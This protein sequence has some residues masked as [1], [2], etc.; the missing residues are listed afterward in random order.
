M[1]TNRFIALVAGVLALGVAACGDD[2]QL[3][4]PTP[5][6]PPPPPPVTATMA[7]ASASVAVGNSVVFAVNASG[8]VAGEAA[9]WTC[10]SSNTGIA[11][12]SSTSA[13]C[14]ATG[15]AA[16]DV[17]I[18]ASV[19]KSGE[20]VN[21]GAQLTVT[22]DE[23]PVVSGD[24][25]FILI[26]AIGDGDTGTSDDDGVLSGEVTV[27][28][29]VERGDQELE[30]LSI[31]VDG[32]V[33]DS[34]SFGSSMDMGMAPEPEDA[35]AAAEQA[36]HAFTL[37]FN[38]AAYDDHG[39]ADYA[40]GEHTIS[41][42]LEI[43]IDMADGTHG[44]E[45][46]SSNAITV[47]F[48]NDD[49]V[50]I[51]ATA[52]GN[53]ALDD[54]GKVWYG[55]PG[56]GLAISVVPVLFSGG[57]VNAVTMMT[58]CGD[59]AATD[60][61]APFEFAPDC[62]GEGETNADASPSFTLTV[63]GEAIAVEADDI[64]NGDD[65]IFPINLDYE[66]PGAPTFRPNP[67][68]REGGWINAAVAFTS[69][70]S[71]NKD[72]W[73]KSGGEAGGVG[74]Y[75]AQLRF[76]AVPR[77]DEDN[78]LTEALEATPLRAVPP[79][80]VPDSRTGSSYCVIAAAV[81]DLGNESRLPDDENGTCQ[82]AGVNSINVEDDPDTGAV[83]ESANNRVATGY[84]K[85]LEDLAAAEEAED[86]EAIE[87]AQDALAD[88]GLRAGV[89]TT[90][91]SAEFVGSSLSS[92][93]KTVNVDETDATTAVTQYVLHLEDNRGL[94]A[95]EPVVDTLVYRDDDDDRDG[96][97][98]TVAQ[99]ATP[100]D[101]PLYDVNFAQEGLGYYSYTAQA[102]DMAGNLSAEITRTALHDT[103]VPVSALIFARS[104]ATEYDKTLVMADNLSVRS[105]STV[106][107]A[108]NLPA[109]VG[110]RLNHA[111]VDTYNGALTQS[112]TVR[113]EVEL[114][115]IAVGGAS[116]DG[117]VAQGDVLTSITAY[118]TDQA[119]NSDN[120]EVTLGAAA[121]SVEADGDL[122]T[123][124]GVIAGTYE[125]AVEDDDGAI[126]T[127]DNANTVTRSDETITLTATADVALATTVNPFADGVLFY[128]EVGG[129]ETGQV[130]VP[131]D[132]SDDRTELR[133]IG[134]VAGNAAEVDSGDTTREWTYET[135]V[136]A[137]DF[138]A[139]VGGAGA[140]EIRALGINGSGVAHVMTFGDPATPLGISRR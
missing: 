57:S 26:S 19:T 91:P 117:S 1:K 37:S 122:E 72:S 40:N 94:R 66:G 64:L 80:A 120:D 50:H 15:V 39:H 108:T 52:P 140:Y 103:E 92:N 46:I 34:Q 111:V 31:L 121:I 59:N 48:D 45:T 118:V 139:I 63:G 115:F 78:G 114:P 76:A 47:D 77:G 35:D 89:D 24:P 28:V 42:E 134:M 128:A 6:Q 43:G 69:T 127:G 7:P 51:A 82:I 20:T 68:D 54:D 119:G 22:S 60:D 11:T 44:H 123:T 109:D 74:G 71:R 90:P 9:S 13:G 70:S 3:V 32:T 56:A 81:D 93:S 21:V 126:T 95:G 79:G 102:Q 105:Y 129:I 41:A 23:E 73:L 75:T 62:E 27:T 29:N 110:L 33:V 25:A 138:Y 99:Q 88:A 113:G 38:S 86:D 106:I 67:N 17:T 30:E 112:E 18:T 8:G 53:S 107:Q 55:G 4:E 16:G 61:E 137:D 97:A 132:T 131:A 136:S 14:S 12:V 124:D 2:V 133:L 87:D 100:D 49:G 83:D 98:T 5:P 84:T 116:P 135:E 58:F 125:L 101:S 130:D 65:D 104:S 85:L 96:V 36:V 10:A